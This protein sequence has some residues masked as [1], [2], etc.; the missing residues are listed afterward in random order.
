MRAVSQGVVA[1]LCVL[2]MGAS[3]V[4]GDT[5]Q[6]SPCNVVHWTRMLEGRIVVEGRDA[7]PLD[8]ESPFFCEHDLPPNHRII[9]TYDDEAT[10]RRPDR[11]SI[12]VD[13][14]NIFLGAYCA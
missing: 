12:Y 13:R 11:L 6:R 3:G 9:H 14:E 5:Y 4:Q 1:M 7:K 8:I 10:D 2:W